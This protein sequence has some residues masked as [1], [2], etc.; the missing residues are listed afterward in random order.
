MEIKGI[1]KPKH[2]KAIFMCG[3]AGTGKTTSRDRFLK[4]QELQLHLSR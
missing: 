2:K 4:T 1:R 3:A